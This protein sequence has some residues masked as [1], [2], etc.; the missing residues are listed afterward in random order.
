MR[1]TNLG[2]AGREPFD[3]LV[4]SEKREEVFG[5]AH[6]IWADSARNNLFVAFSKQIELEVPADKFRV[7]VSAS[8]HYELYV[9]GEFVNRG[10]I[11]GDPKW[12]HFDEIEVALDEPVSKLEMFALVHHSKGTDLHYL[13][14]APGGFICT[15]GRVGPNIMVAATDET[16]RCTILEMW[17]ED[18]PQRNWALDYCEEY[19]AREEPNG[20]R[21]K[22]IPAEELERWGFAR[23][24]DRSDELWGSYQ[25]RV[26][27]L[28]KR[29][30]VEPESYRAYAAAGRGAALVFEVSEYC[31]DEE[32]VA[33]AGGRPYSGRVIGEGE[34]NAFTFDLGA[35]Y[36]GFYNIEVEAAPGTVIEISGAELLQENSDRPW[37]YRKRTNYSVRYIC[38]EGARKY[39]SF[40]WSGFRYLHI[41]VR[42][43]SVSSPWKIH[44]VAAVERSAQYAPGPSVS[45]DDP[46]LESIGRL[47]ERTIMIGAQELLVDCPTREQSP[48]WVDSLIVSVGILNRFA[49]PSY[50][51][52]Y[53]EAYLKAP[54]NEHGLFHA[55]Y[56]STL[57]KSYWLD[58]CLVAIQGQYFYWRA[59]GRYYKPRESLARGL[60]VKKWFDREKNSDGIIDFPFRE[61]YERSL[62]NFI[63]HP[64]LGMHD[65]PHPG[66]DR[67]GASCGLNTHLYAY[68]RE[69]ALI[70]REVDGAGSIADSLEAEAEDLKRA[71]RETF[72][73]GAVFHDAR[74]EGVLSPF[75]SWQTNGLAVYYD[76]A[77][78]LEARVIMK[79]MLDQ[80]DS[81]CRCTPHTHF[82]FLPSLKKAG[83][84]DEARKLIKR[85]W[86]RMIEGN[87]TCTW[88]GFEGDEKDTL[89][90]PWA[91]TPLLYLTDEF[92]SYL[93]PPSVFAPKESYYEDS[94]RKFQGIPAIER[95]ANG[96][97]WAAWYGGGETED[98]FN[99]VMIATRSANEEKWSSPVLIIDPDRDGPVRA[100]DP[101]LWHDPIGR[102]WCFWSQ[103]LEK[104]RDRRGGVWA[105]M[106]EDS[107]A[108][109]P[110]W[111]A[112]VRLFDGIMMNKPIET[113]WGEW[114]FP[115]AQWHSVQSA[116]VYASADEGQTFE[117][118]G[119]ASIPPNLRNCD[120]HVI[121]EYDDESLGLYIRTKS[122]ISESRSFD[123]GGKWS[124]PVPSK[125]SHPVS[126]FCIRRLRSGSLLLVKHGPLHEVTQRELLTAYLSRDDGESWIGGLTIDERRGVSYPDSVESPDGTIRVVYDFERKGEG[127]ILLASFRESDILAGG[128]ESDGSGIETVNCLRKAAKVART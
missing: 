99:Y 114:L 23:R 115:V 116:K 63:D 91:T 94:G 32:L 48:A 24:V 41:V 52:W 33:I 127:S 11:H 15:I 123:R 34:A 101:S 64:G 126:R 53:L 2:S 111:T 117:F 21:E 62:R 69:H 30:I 40:L 118:R 92:S 3:E 120:E 122:G 85:E 10:P 51:L 83:M 1:V 61:Y 97:L 7:V 124:T 4:Q 18:V 42:G 37:I 25:R 6:W 109:V 84:G 50:L 16:W 121:V 35:E 59:V 110:E 29:R 104:Q 82:Y 19:D 81:L 89:C 8:Y 13:T 96:R 98:R 65:S 77:D 57:S 31:D 79:T 12:C 46:M 71:I 60:E 56:P 100:F 95:T 93:D 72:F 105:M 38:G 103:G 26:T 102:L 43:E 55:R 80:Y 66:I 44:K 87:A 17:S 88:E 5:A 14:P 36:I 86:G 119:A 125:L 108:A 106:T 27:P 90:H 49:D 68:V 128:F 54:L 20:W 75:T 107:E 76:L 28:L 45:V 22:R 58:F 39:T 74:K 73:D 47:C 112:P 113:S 78:P 67:D 70:A 9:N